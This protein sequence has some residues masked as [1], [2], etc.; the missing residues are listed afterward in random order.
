MGFPRVRFTV[1]RAMVAVA[2]LG[3]L[4]AWP[5]RGVYQT[6]LRRRTIADILGHGGSVNYREGGLG[7]FLGKADPKNLWLFKDAAAVDLA[8]TEA[9]DADLEPLRDSKSLVF[10]NLT[11]CRITDV[12]VAK[13]KGIANLKY[14]L[15]G[16]TKV[17]NEGLKQI[18]GLSSLEILVLD[19][20]RIS[21][22]G[23]AGLER[24]GKLRELS[25][26]GTLVSDRGTFCLRSL[27]AL[28]S[29]S[30]PRSDAGSSHLAEFQKELPGVA[31]YRQPTTIPH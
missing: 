11:G 28:T 17:T 30:L 24:L 21:D 9:S 8:G 5:G 2:V 14:L 31:V 29:V 3:L 1:R 22:P 26:W 6:V 18:S 27:P 19:N 20:T 23:L 13:L 12:G 16:D 7:V 4:S 15:M 10:L 25:L